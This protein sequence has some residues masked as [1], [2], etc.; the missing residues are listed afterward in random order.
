MYKR[1]I[2]W[3][4]ILQRDRSTRSLKHFYENIFMKIKCKSLYTRKK[5]I[6]MEMF[7]SL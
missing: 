1:E 6:K 3:R 7:D 4:Q 2:N 5:I